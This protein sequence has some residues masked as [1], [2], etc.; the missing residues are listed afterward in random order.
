MQSEKTQPFMVEECS[1]VHVERIHDL[2]RDDYAWASIAMISLLAQDS[3]LIGSWAESCPCHPLETHPRANSKATRAARQ[4]AKVCPF[5]CCRAPELAVGQGLQ[6]L[7]D[8]MR[9]HHGQFNECVAKAPPAKR[10]ELTSSWTTA[11]SKLFGFLCWHWCRCTW[12]SIIFTKWL[13]RIL[14]LSA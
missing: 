1:K 6:L 5:R 9:N 2:M 10:S 12:L 14:L 4:A 3:D 11:C 7:C 8:R 13:Y